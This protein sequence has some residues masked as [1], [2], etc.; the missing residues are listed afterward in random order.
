MKT[1]TH[2]PSLLGLPIFFLCQILL[3]CADHEISPETSG[4]YF[5][6]AD[7]TEQDYLKEY[8]KSDD[9]IT[10]WY[11]DTVT[12]TVLGDTLIEG[13]VYKKIMNDYGLLEKV[14]RQEGSKFFGRNHELYGGFSHEFM[15]LDTEVPVDGSW[16]YLKEEGHTKTEYI[17]K[18]VHAKQ[19]VQGVEYKDV[20]KLEVNYYDNYTDGINFE[21]RY[22]AKHDYAKGIGEI[23]AY[24][25]G[26]SS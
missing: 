11:S 9:N 17:V 8:V 3:S 4:D 14:V 20:I 5:L 19:T 1:I 18:A 26:T 13:L 24:Y 25:P 7:N 22:S 16:E 2:F 10:I 6:I 23:Y 15:F 21:Y 12:L